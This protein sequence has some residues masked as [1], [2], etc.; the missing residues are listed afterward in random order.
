MVYTTN[1]LI[2]TNKEH[3]YLFIKGR[4]MKFVFN[5]FKTAK[6]FGS[7]TFF[8]NSKDDKILRTIIKNR[9]F[10]ENDFIYPS[11][12][13]QFSRDMN[14]ITEKVFGKKLS[15]IDLRVLHSSTE[16]KGINPEKIFKD[17]EQS[18]HSVNTKI[19]SYIRQKK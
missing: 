1:P 9:N 6:T 7:Q 14:K 12:D 5:I 4:S 2:L 15:V 3:N 10:K 13:R 8:L 11:G 18:G 19:T 17:A 16:F